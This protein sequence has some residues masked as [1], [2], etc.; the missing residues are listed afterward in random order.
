ME[1]K[2][3]IL[4]IA[5][6]SLL[7]ALFVIFSVISFMPSK[8]VKGFAGFAGSISK[9]F[10]LE[11]GIYA[12]YTPSKIG[13]MTDEDVFQWWLSKQSLEKWKAENILTKDLFSNT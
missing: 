4:K 10:D 12:N 8:A 7:A 13:E 9:G 1:K 2:K 5:L 11:G 3:A 6:I